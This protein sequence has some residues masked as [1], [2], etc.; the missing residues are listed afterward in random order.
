MNKNK[1]AKSSSLIYFK[2][3]FNLPPLK[4]HLPL[5]NIRRAKFINDT[6][7]HHAISASGTVDLVGLVS[8]YFRRF[9]ENFGTDDRLSKGQMNGRAGGQTDGVVDS[10]T[11]GRKRAREIENENRKSEEQRDEVERKESKKERRKKEK[12]TQ[13]R[14]KKK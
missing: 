13:G 2:V 12:K 3:V 10:F 8:L 11:D 14:E 7:Y 6:L 5:F 4:I 1:P 9:L